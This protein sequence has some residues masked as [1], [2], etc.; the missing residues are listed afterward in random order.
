MKIAKLSLV[1]ILSLT[2]INAVASGSLQDALKSGKA[3][4]KA[5][6]WYQTNDQKDLFH[7]MSSIGNAGLELGYVS[8]DY[9]NLGF[10]VTFYALDSLNLEVGR[11]DIVSWTPHGALGVGKTS[12][13][14][15]ESYLTYKFEKTLFK[16]G[17]QN[18]A[19][20]L[21]NSDSWAVHPNNFEAFVVVN[22]DLPNTTLIGAY[23][24]KERTRSEDKFQ[25]FMS[26]AGT[27]SKGAMMLAALHN[28]IKGT[29]LR[30]FYY[31]VDEIAQAVYGDVSTKIANMNAAFQYIAMIPQGD[32]KR[33]AGDEVTHAVAV[34][35][36]VDVVGLNIDG[37]I[38][39]INNGTLNVANTGD[40]MTKTPVFTKTITGDAD[41]AGATDTVGYRI[42]MNKTLVDKLKTFLTF[43]YYY[44]GEDS[45][46]TADSGEKDE[47]LTAEAV[48]KYD[49]S[50]GLNLFTSYMYTDHSTGA[51]R[52]ADDDSHH[53]IRVWAKY[54]F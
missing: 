26:W 36:G 8:G 10:G 33:A 47:S 53:T 39:Y 44:H 24:T 28:G 9:N 38:S 27:T 11:H 7:K 5:T 31:N 13:W 46:A 48:L 22:S 40:K 50:N 54:G 34:K 21:A 20:P 35:A 29:P 42:S 23:V 32:L 14:L 51:Y 49:M 15:G 6:I 18:L 2:G 37:A 45:S 43:A 12:S 52:Y 25:D 19:T 30:G 3:S 4:G 41:I 16:V 1:T 17:R